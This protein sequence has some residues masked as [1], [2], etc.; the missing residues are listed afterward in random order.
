MA[1]IIL[2]H[3][4]PTHPSTPTAESRSSI[5]RPITP[6]HRQCKTLSLVGQVKVRK[7]KT[8]LDRS[9]FKLQQRRPDLAP[10]IG[11]VREVKMHPERTLSPTQREVAP[12]YMALFLEALT[13]GEKQDFVEQSLENGDLNSALEILEKAVNP[14]EQR[15]LFESFL[16]LVRDETKLSLAARLL[17]SRDFLTHLH[18]LNVSQRFNLN[19]SFKGLALRLADRGDLTSAFKVIGEAISDDYSKEEAKGDVLYAAHKNGRYI[20]AVAAVDQTS[21]LRAHKMAFRKALSVNDFSAAEELMGKLPASEHTI[22][23]HHFAEAYLEIGKHKTALEFLATAELKPFCQALLGRNVNLGIAFVSEIS[24]EETRNSILDTAAKHYS[25]IMQPVNA[26]K[27]ISKMTDSATRRN[28]FKRLQLAAKTQGKYDK[29]LSALVSPGPSPFNGLPSTA[30]TKS[31]EYEEALE[32]LIKTGSGST[33][34]CGFHYLALHCL[35]TRGFEAAEAIVYLIDNPI[36]R[37][38]ALSQLKLLLVS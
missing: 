23:R 3:L 6:I 13:P 17:H 20:E 33:R 24:N 10:I 9:L 14:K 16:Q 38:N 22:C 32:M 35:S 7:Q 18:K 21:L 11:F 12:E 31:G 30:S 36:R 15:F 29:F 19:G 4:G 27:I 34:D 25:I 28:A 26:M 37:Q 5:P 2:G 8:K 1:E